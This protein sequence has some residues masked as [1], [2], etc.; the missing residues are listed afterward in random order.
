MIGTAKRL[1]GV[2]V[3]VGLFGLGLTAALMVGPA[4]AQVATTAATTTLA[5]A[6]T[7]VSTGT[8]TTATTGENGSTWI[9]VVLV[10]GLALFFAVPYL[11]DVI[12]T[13]RRWNALLKAAQGNGRRLTPDELS[14]FETKTPLGI[15]GLARS[16]MAFSVIG[17]LGVAL[18]Y[19]LV[20]TPTTNS[21]TIIS[22]LL[23]TLGTLAT[24][25][26][27]FYFGTRAAQGADGGAVG[28]GGETPLVAPQ[29]AAPPTIGGTPMQ[30]STLTGSPGVWTGLPG[31]YE[32]QWQREGGEDQWTAI[33]SGQSYQVAPEDAGHRLRVTVTATNSGGTSNPAS[34]APVTA[35]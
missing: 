24:A 4:T 11:I 33:A 6:E 14:G 16:L 29:N 35:S 30:G 13:H 26:I 28:V 32:Y 15:D 27:A 2:M 34:S 22:N 21:G 31:T 19:V 3:V 7:R 25:I 9:F 18:F 12:S 10:L 17:I 5:P 8:G 1:T 20:K 23:S